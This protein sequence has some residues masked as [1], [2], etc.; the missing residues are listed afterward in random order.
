MK[1]KAIDD[2]LKD[3]YPCIVERLSKVY[4]QNEEYRQNIEKENRLEDLL[5]KAFSGEQ[6]RIVEEYHDAVCATLNICE[7]LAYRQG[8]RDLAEIL[9]IGDKTDRIIVE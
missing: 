1:E 7:V 9:G 5:E 3:Y 4:N 8:M 2:I 6:L